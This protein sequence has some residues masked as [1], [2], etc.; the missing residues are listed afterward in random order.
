MKGA[1]GY[2]IYFAK[3]GRKLMPP[4]YVAKLRY[5][6]SDKRIAAVSKTGRITAVSKGSCKVYA[7]AANGVRKA[8]KVTVR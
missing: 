4:S 8:V 3:Y 1:E 5:I 7:L 2:D 6:S